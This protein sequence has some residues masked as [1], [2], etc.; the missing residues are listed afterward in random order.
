MWCKK[1]GGKLVKTNDELISYEYKCNFCGHIIDGKNADKIL[2]KSKGNKILGLILIIIGVLI[3][4]DNFK[5]QIISKLVN[6]PLGVLFSGLFGT[7]LI[8]I[9]VF[10][11]MGKI[12]LIQH[13]LYSYNI[14]TNPKFK[15]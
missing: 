1:C 14:R 5:E 15:R 11:I 13:I 10:S 3:T 4:L 8:I 12:N 9:G 2:K 6:L 7:L